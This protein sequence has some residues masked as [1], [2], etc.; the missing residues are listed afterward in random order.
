[1]PAPLLNN[2]QFLLPDYMIDILEEVSTGTTY[3][4]ALLNQM[5]RYNAQKKI[6]ANTI[7]I[8]W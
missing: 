7:L 3:K 2:T 6:A 5:N 8:V 4:T 1:M